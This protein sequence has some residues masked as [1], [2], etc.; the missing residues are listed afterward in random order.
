[1]PFPLDLDEWA[2]ILMMVEELHIY[3]DPSL[4]HTVVGVSGE[5]H[6]EGTIPTTRSWKI[7]EPFF[8]EVPWDRTPLRSF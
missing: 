6:Q 7:L 2:I 4:G 8:E 5:L 1:M 3:E